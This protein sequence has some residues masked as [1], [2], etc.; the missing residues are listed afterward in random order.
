MNRFFSIILAAFVGANVAQ[1]QNNT[2]SPYTRYGYGELVQ[3]GFGYSNSRGGLSVGLRNEN[4]INSGNPA[5]FTAID[6]MTF[7]FEFGASIKRSSFQDKE[8][9]QT[10]WDQNLEY[11][12]MQFPVGRYFGFS[13]G[14]QP[15]SFVGYE[16]SN[17]HVQ[18][19]SISSDTLAYTNSYIG[20]GNL[21]QL[22]LGLGA[23]PFSN[24]HVGVNAY[25]NF[26][27]IEHLSQVTFDN[28]AYHSSSQTNSMKVHD[29]A[30]GFG[31]Q[32]VFPL[33]EN[34]SLVVGATLDLPSVLTASADRE[35]ITNYVDTTKINFDDSFGLPLGFGTGFEYELSESLTVGAEYRFQKWSDVEYFG[36][37]EF[38][39]RHR[40]ACGL[41]WVPS[42]MSKNF[43]KRVSYRAGLNYSNSYFKV[44]GDDVKHYGASF[45]LGLPL[46]RTANPSILNLGV[47]YGRAG[48]KSDDLILEQYFKFTLNLSINERWF[49][50]RKFE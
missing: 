37:K 18:P 22:Y 40:L 7:R 20:Q 30:V 33:A 14:L 25:F 42:S 38:N 2:S 48:E 29:W 28:G 27:S 34:R 11:M 5:S 47:E 35:V 4:H 12:A 39:D 24:L 36:K 16:F 31:A 15:F 23:N 46:R 8:R 10:S 6:S 9:E 26:G 49:A 13:A 44:N 50:K 17:R 41:D 32:Y 45:G 43:F 1:A 19:S 3:P 21:T